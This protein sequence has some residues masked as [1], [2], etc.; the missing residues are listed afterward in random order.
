MFT[1]FEL[2]AHIGHLN[3]W[4]KMIGCRGSN[5]IAS[6]LYTFIKTKSEADVI[7]FFI[8]SENCGGATKTYSP[9]FSRHLWTSRSK[10]HTD[11]IS[12]QRKTIKMN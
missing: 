12:Q 10:L 9:R 8:Y 7:E 6:L 5:E 11:E 4:N 3:V 1:N 2:V